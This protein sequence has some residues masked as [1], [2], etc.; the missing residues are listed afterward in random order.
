MVIAVDM[1]RT[2]VVWW[3]RNLNHMCSRNR[4]FSYLE[5]PPPLTARTPNPETMDKT[6]GPEQDIKIDGIPSRDQSVTKRIH[7]CVL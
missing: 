7:V 3:I 4:I 6:I 5:K 1:D 2:A